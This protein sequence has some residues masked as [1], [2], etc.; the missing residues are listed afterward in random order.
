MQIQ[1]FT[2]QTKS[3]LTRFYEI[4]DEM[5]KGMTEAELTNSIS[6]NFIVQMI[7]H[8]M[9]A[10]EMSENILKYSAYVP[11]RNIASGIITE[12]TKSI[13]D[14]KAVLERCSM[15]ENCRQDLEL[16]QKRTQHITQVMF[17]QMGT[18]CEDNDVNGDFMREMI[19][20]H[21]GA[22]R[23]SQNALSFTICQEL[24]PILYAIITSQQEGVR[25][26]ECLLKC[27]TAAFAKI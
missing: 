14:M 4:L 25:K 24:K 21:R 8:H 11:V 1:R 7:P 12:Q 18:A 22:I 5:I 9:A 26:M 3:Y 19:P 17:S 15:T 2:E 10:I 16:Y 23:M 27:N 13:A 6:H 20:H